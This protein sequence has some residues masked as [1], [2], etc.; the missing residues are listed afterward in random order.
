VAAH[1]KV[2][3]ISYD[4]GMQQA[5]GR[6]LNAVSFLTVVYTSAEAL[7][8]HGVVEE[9]DGVISDLKLS[10]LSGLDLLAEFNAWGRRPPPILITAHDAPGLRE[11]AM[12]LGALA[13]LAKPFR[14]TERTGSPERGDRTIRTA[15]MTAA[16]RTHRWPLAGF[17]P[18]GW[19]G[20]PQRLASGNVPTRA[21]IP[22]P[23]NQRGLRT[24]HEKDHRPRPR[25][26]PHACPRR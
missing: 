2:I 22:S 17:G 24:C 18:R 25:T 20:H 9:T 11:E 19:K 7:L 5:L 26:S 6:L 16:S 15:A 23:P 12:R 8:A 14:G 3:L 4:D 21:S 10:G 1:V 13:Y